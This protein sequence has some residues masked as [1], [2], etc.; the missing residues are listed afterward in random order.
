MTDKTGWHGHNHSPAESRAGPMAIRFLPTERFE[1]PTEPIYK[2]RSYP[3]P[4]KTRRRHSIGLLQLVLLMVVLLVDHTCAVYVNFQ[5][6]LNPSILESSDPQQLQFVPLFVWATFN[7]SSDSHD[8]NVTV[9]GNVTGIA[10][11]QPYPLLNDTQWT[12]PN[13][14]IGKIP[15]IAGPEEDKKYTTFQT[16]YHVLDYAPYNPDATRFCNSSSLTPCPIAPAFNL[17]VDE[18]VS[19]ISLQLQMNIANLGSDLQG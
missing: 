18:Y 11:Q 10:T 7:T 3:P 15:D 4:W 14:T 8:L 9:Y 13:D 1:K 5:N 2:I 17:T 16:S 6:C 12:N 19:L